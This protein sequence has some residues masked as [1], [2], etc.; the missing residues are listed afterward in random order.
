MLD[1]ADVWFRTWFCPAM[2]HDGHADAAGL[3]II[4][5]LG[6]MLHRLRSVL[7]AMQ[8]AMDNLDLDYILSLDHND[9]LTQVTSTTASGILSTDITKQCDIP[10]ALIDMV[11]GSDVLGALTFTNIVDNPISWSNM[12]RDGL[13]RLDDSTCTA[14][15]VGLRCAC[16]HQALLGLVRPHP[17]ALSKHYLASV[18]RLQSRSDDHEAWQNCEPN[19]WY[20]L[21]DIPTLGPIRFLKKGLIY[22]TDIGGWTPNRFRFAQDDVPDLQDRLLCDKAHAE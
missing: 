18:E 1:A 4:R 19:I 14:E 6:A 3:Q 12:L 15:V 13:C 2:T 11:L 16:C 10:A 9:K 7:R 17:T 5:I 8:A 20:Y 21:R 22:G